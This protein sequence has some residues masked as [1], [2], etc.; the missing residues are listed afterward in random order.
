M[1]V[2]L[3]GKTQSVGFLWD[4]GQFAVGGYVLIQDVA[5]KS[6]F[7][8]LPKKFKIKKMAVMN[9]DGELENKLMANHSVIFKNGVKYS[10]YSFTMKVDKISDARIYDA[11][12][13][14][15]DKFG[16]LAALKG[17]LPPCG[18]QMGMP[19]LNQQV[20]EVATN[21]IN[22]VVASYGIAE[23]PCN[24]VSAPTEFVL[25]ITAPFDSYEPS[26]SQNI[27]S[28]AGIALPPITFL[29][30][31]KYDD[32]VSLKFDTHMFYTQLKKAGEASGAYMNV[33]LGLK[34]SMQN[35]FQNLTSFGLMNFDIKEAD[36]IRHEELRRHYETIFIDMLTHMLYQFE[37][38]V[39]PASD[40]VTIATQGSNA[41]T[42]FKA[43][44]AM[45]EAEFTRQDTMTLHVKNTNYST[46]TSQLIIDLTA[47]KDME[48]NL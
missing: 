13:A 30:T 6:D 2:P 29:H 39:P 1:L 16:M 33:G 48:I 27:L 22:G 45:S 19:K 7:Y 36:P 5:H 12:V 26:L 20:G 46:V 21:E 34:K 10:K 43:S 4:G 17:M 28:G 44:I 9:N 42:Y 23:S 25:E 11:T 37:A 14:L 18:I 31:A 35:T 41:G 32:D 40:D 8:W 47:A 15:R 38:I 3:K 24:L